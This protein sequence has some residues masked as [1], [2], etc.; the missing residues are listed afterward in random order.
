[1]MRSFSVRFSYDFKAAS[2]MVW[3]FE[4]VGAVVE[5][6]DMIGVEVVEELIDSELCG[7]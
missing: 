2:K 5:V 1:M 6:C 3:K 4:E 7:R